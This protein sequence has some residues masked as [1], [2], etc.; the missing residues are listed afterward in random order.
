MH[1]LLQPIELGSLRLRNRII[2]APMTRNRALAGDVPGELAAVYYGARAAAGLI[3][4][5]G[6]Q[7]SKHGK[8]Y[9]RTPGL[10]SAA[11]VQGWQRV[12]DAVH[13]AGGCIVVQ[14]MHCGRIGSQYNKDA[15]ARTV[16]PSAVRAAGKMFTD[17]AGLVDFDLPE[18][19]TLPEIQAVIGE[20][21]AAA[22][23]AQ[24]AGFDGVELHGASGYLPMQFLDRH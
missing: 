12:T 22:R 21:A 13:A 24:Q 8:G 14:L 15:D 6:T 11:Q 1:E 9:C 3:V 7:P 20:Y 17:A 16:A 19:L 5:E 4:T 2:M 18:A 10:Y 23:A